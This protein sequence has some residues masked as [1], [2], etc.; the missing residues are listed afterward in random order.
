MAPAYTCPRCGSKSGTGWQAS[1]SD[2]G[3]CQA[4]TTLKCAL[5][6]GQPQVKIKLAAWP[7]WRCCPPKSCPETCQLVQLNSNPLSIQLYVQLKRC[8][9]ADEINEVL[10]VYIEL[11]PFS[12]NDIGGSCAALLSVFP[13]WNACCKLWI[14]C[15]FGK[16]IIMSALLIKSKLIAS[17]TFV[18]VSRSDNPSR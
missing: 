5:V 1:R 16:M 15:F 3:P 13:F 18:Q 10:C 6:S 12:V 14:Q 11:K 2:Q 4:S 8:T 9:L 7:S 17:Q